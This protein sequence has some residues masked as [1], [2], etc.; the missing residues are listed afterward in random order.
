LRLIP[1][2]ANISVK[3]TYTE[4]IESGRSPENFLSVEGIKV[5]SILLSCMYIHIFFLIFGL[6]ILELPFSNLDSSVY[7]V[8]CF[9]FILIMLL[10]I[11]HWGLY[12]LFIF[13]II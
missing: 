10:F 12:V 11:S 2:L 8:A 7:F 1:E 3:F 4:A 9:E 6:Y 13:Y 5:D